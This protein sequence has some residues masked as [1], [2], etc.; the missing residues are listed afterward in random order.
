MH[1]IIPM[2]KKRTNF[3]LKK[4]LFTEVVFFSLQ[5]FHQN[6]EFTTCR[7]F[8]INETLLFTASK[9]GPSIHKLLYLQGK[10]K[11]KK[12]LCLEIIHFSS[13]FF[14]YKVVFSA[15]RLFKINENLL[16]TIAGAITTYLIVVIQFDVAP[17]SI[18][19]NGFLQDIVWFRLGYTRVRHLQLCTICKR[20]NN[21]F[22]IQILFAITQS[23]VTI[24]IVVIYTGR[25]I[26][27]DKDVII[28]YIVYAFLQMSLSS[29]QVIFV[30][31]I[32]SITAEEAS[33][34]GPLIHKLLYLQGKTKLKKELSLEILHFST[35]FFHYKVV[36][37]AG[38]LFK[39]N[40]NLLFTIAGA[41]TTYLIVVIQFDVAPFSM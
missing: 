21:A 4:E 1:N 8:P 22:S 34:S 30:V 29:L 38:R 2:F 6:L 23:F 32:C 33:K 20:C 39:I 36:F 12:E 7:L 11:L 18:V 28:Q 10:N 27:V 15:G 35:Q 14:H 13:Q 40:E 37:S 5:L 19:S 3:Y 26:F 24:V 9:S 25:H 16:F 41:I 17:F 31:I